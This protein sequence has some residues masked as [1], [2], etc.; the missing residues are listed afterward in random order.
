MK[1]RYS[2]LTFSLF[3]TVLSAQQYVPMLD[4]VNEWHYVGNYIPVRQ[5]QASQVA[6]LPCSFPLFFSQSMTEFTTH[7]TV[8]N[9]LTYKIVNSMQ[10]GNPTPCTYGYMRE[11]TAARK[12]FFVNNNFDPEILLYDFS[13]Q[14]GDTMT[15]NFMQQGYIFYNGLYTLDSITQVH[16]NAGWR[17]AFH[18]NNHAQS[19]SHTLTWVESMGNYYDAFYQNAN[20]GSGN[21]IPFASCSEFPHENIQF[22]TCFDHMSKVYYDSCAYHNAVTNMCFYTQDTCN[23][24]DICG[25]VKEIS[26]VSSM[27][28]FPNPSCGKTTLSLEIKHADDFSVRVWD[29]SGKEMIKEI[30]LGMLMAGEKKIDLD[31]SSLSNGFY[32]VEL[33]TAEGSVY[34]KL[35]LER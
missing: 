25:S 30:P 26:S 23:Y 13:M 5:Q 11:D 31:L 18:L 32:L 1:K 22:M 24:Y 9:A 16:I 10:D 14:I 17:R 2:L 35:L 12:V 19:A 6:N 34:Q 33:K 4:S 3:A 28:I 29:I 7:D 21:F 15:V 20:Y 27:D 8:M